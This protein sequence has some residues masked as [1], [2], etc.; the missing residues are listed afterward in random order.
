MQSSNAR[1]QITSFDALK[2]QVGDLLGLQNIGEYRV[3]L[4]RLLDSFG[5]PTVIPRRI[6]PDKQIPAILPILTMEQL[7]DIASEIKTHAHPDAFYCF[8]HYLQ[9]PLFNTET[10]ISTLVMIAQ[11]QDLSSRQASVIDFIRKDIL[12][13]DSQKKYREY[14]SRAEN[15]QNGTSLLT[16]S[17]SSAIYPEN[18]KKR[19][20]E[21]VENPTVG[22]GV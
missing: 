6:V 15:I 14:R 7:F 12:S 9:L 2:K 19:K 20:V 18:N 17:T 4:I 3:R 13:E 1:T 5:K 22:N 10:Q 11:R 8:N 21:E 16:S